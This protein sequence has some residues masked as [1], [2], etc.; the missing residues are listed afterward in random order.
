MNAT[1]INRSAMKPITTATRTPATTEAMI[2]NNQEY[3][4][5]IEQIEND[6]VNFINDGMAKGLF[7]FEI[8]LMMFEISPFISYFFNMLQNCFQCVKLTSEIT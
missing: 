7:D 6:V 1:A 5:Q 3:Y 4:N 8:D 2:D